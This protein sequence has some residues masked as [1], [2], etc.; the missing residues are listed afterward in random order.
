MIDTATPKELAEQYRSK[1]WW[2]K[3]TLWDR[4]MD[5]AQ[6]KPD[7]VAVVDGD[8]VAE[9]EHTFGQLASDSAKLACWLREQGM[10]AGDVASVQL[11]NVY[12]A[13]VVAL[14]LQQV[15]MVINP[16]LPNYRLK[17]LSYIF[18]KAETKVVFIPDSYRGFDHLTLIDDVS[19]EARLELLQVIVGVSTGEHPTLASILEG[20]APEVI[21]PSELDPSSMSEIIFSSGTEAEPKA[22]MHTEQTTSFSVRNVQEWL[23][24]A[25]HD[26][27]YMPSP[28][29]HSTGF[30]Y[31]LRLAMH[32]G[33]K[34]VLQDKW[35]S[36]VAVDLIDRHQ[37]TYTLA[38]TT[39]L[40][41]LS[42]E[43]RVQERTLPSLRLFGCGGAPVPSELVDAANAVGIR[44]Q[45][46]YGSTEVLAVTWHEPES[47]LDRRRDSDGHPVINVEMELRD[48]NERVC[49]VQEPGE[50][51]VRSPGTSVGYFQDPER[52]AATYMPDGWIRTGDIGEIDEAGD[53]RIVGRKKEIIIR[54]GLNIA[55]REIEDML[56]AMPQIEQ[57]AVVGIADARL[58]E[59]CCACVRLREG[60]SLDFESMVK[61][62]SAGGLAKYKLPEAL[63][64]FD[65]LPMTSTGKVQK[66][67]ILSQLEGRH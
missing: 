31:G 7:A 44:V 48:D 23:S 41:E 5:H 8:S 43:L 64:L 62:L 36:K 35:D 60:E 67:M 66:H 56:V 39:F 61:L 59:K 47:S 51:L 3:D 13:V 63:E 9:R 25:D 55:P 57:A 19:R 50:I 28:V 32:L 45:R 52:T 27:V 58:G 30:N 54:G 15:G 38:A 34:L 6:T 16:V 22:V 14:G 33:L 10:R 12:E 18:T 29:G 53:L 65:E 1:G 17:E 46:L 20:S 49:G 42:D 26:V 21:P 2:N 37:C 40:K 24:L 11:P 4:F